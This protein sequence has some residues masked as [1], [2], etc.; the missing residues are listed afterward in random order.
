MLETAQTRFKE[1]AIGEDLKIYEKE[2]KEEIQKQFAAAKNSYNE[3]SKKAIARKLQPEIQAM[4]SDI[5]FDK[6]TSEGDLK[7]RLV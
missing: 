1:K 7:E 2:I 6:I 5:R 4:E 3:S